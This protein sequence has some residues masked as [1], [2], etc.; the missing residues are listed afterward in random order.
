MA[1]VMKIH[2]DNRKIMDG[3][4]G[5]PVRAGQTIHSLR[6]KLRKRERQMFK[7]TRLKAMWD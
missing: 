5:A 6:D 7:Q 3:V 1:T 2:I 4:R